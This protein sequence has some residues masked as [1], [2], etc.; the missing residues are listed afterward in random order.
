MGNS[1]ANKLGEP[2]AE[3]DVSFEEK[4]TQTEI[5]QSFTRAVKLPDI[6]VQLMMW[7]SV[8]NYDRGQQTIQSKANVEAP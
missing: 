7:K 1:I 6:L 3:L 4:K 2:Q 8:V 5:K